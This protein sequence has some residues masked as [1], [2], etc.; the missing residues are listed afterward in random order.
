MK[1][2]QLGLSRVPRSSSRIGDGS[3]RFRTRIISSGV[4]P[5]AVTLAMKAPALVPT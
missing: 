1:P 4:I 2:R 5:L 3:L